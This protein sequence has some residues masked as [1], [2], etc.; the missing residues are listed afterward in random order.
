MVKKKNK[1]EDEKQESH[2]KI[3]RFTK[4]SQ[5]EK[6]AMYLRN[7]VQLLTGRWTQNVHLSLEILVIVGPE[8]NYH[9][10]KWMG[11]GGHYP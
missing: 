9:K 4:T 10:L 8:K 7:C 5:S 6:G 11:K 2:H 3:G 1:S